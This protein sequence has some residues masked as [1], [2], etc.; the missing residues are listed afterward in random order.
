[1]TCAFGQLTKKVN[2]CPGITPSS[3]TFANMIKQIELSTGNTLHTT[4]NQFP[5]INKLEVGWSFLL[6]AESCRNNKS[7]LLIFNDPHR[8]FQILSNIGISKSHTK[9]FCHHQSVCNPTGQRPIN[10]CSS[11]RESL[12]KALKCRYKPDKAI[13][14]QTRH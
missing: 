6:F 8:R 10:V 4:H 9:P 14:L 5:H 13:P 2:A 3:C 12:G 11:K 7:I 1:M